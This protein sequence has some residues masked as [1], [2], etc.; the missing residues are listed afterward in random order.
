MKEDKGGGGFSGEEGR[1]RPF[2]FSGV[3][4]ATQVKLA[5]EAASPAPL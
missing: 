5:A 3:Q 1:R 2:A 4:G